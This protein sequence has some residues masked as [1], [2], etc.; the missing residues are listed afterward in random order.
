MV[1]WNCKIQILLCKVRKY[2]V[3]TERDIPIPSAVA[4]ACATFCDDVF[5]K[6]TESSIDCNC[7]LPVVLIAL[8]LL[9]FQVTL[10]L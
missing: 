6:M 10:N 7:N 5:S 1:K 9:A 4:H 3:L 2:C 8:S